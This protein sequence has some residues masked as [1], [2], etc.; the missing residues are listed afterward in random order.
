MPTAGTVDTAQVELA[1]YA[2]DTDA[3]LVV[4]HP[5]TGELIP[6]TPVKADG[7]RYFRAR[8]PYPVPGVW[9]HGWT[10]TGTGEGFVEKYVPVGPAGVAG[11]PRHTY[12]TTVD[13]AHV[14]H[15]APPIDADRLLRDASADLDDLLLTAV[16]DVDGDGMP[17]VDA[18]CPDGQTLVTVALRDAVCQMVK[19]RVDTGDTDGA[20]SVYTS[21]SVAGVNLSR[22]DAGGTASRP[23]RVGDAARAVI[24]RAGLLSHGPYHFG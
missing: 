15:E 22:R 6:Y 24:S 13:L 18:L 9:W 11:D 1:V 4:R 19:W 8:V 20:A 5:G 21:A 17:T 2:S 12:A 14:L 3:S 10:V 16:Y 7:G 23:D